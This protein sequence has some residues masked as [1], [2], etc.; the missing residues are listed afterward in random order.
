MPFGEFKKKPIKKD[1]KTIK[2]EKAPFHKTDTFRLNFREANR[3]NMVF[4][5]NR[6]TNKKQQC[7]REQIRE[8][9]QRKSD[10]LHQDSPASDYFIIAMDFGNGKW[11]AGKPTIPGDPVSL[12]NETDSDVEE[13]GTPIRFDITFTIPK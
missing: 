2:K 5:S 11:K 9:A 6:Y 1:Q 3:P 7:D 10:E 12:W 8:F 4:Y 13:H